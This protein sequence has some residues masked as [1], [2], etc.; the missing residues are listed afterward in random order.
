M[1]HILL[2]GAGKS[3]SYLIEYLKKISTDRKW[4]I[5]VAD[6]QIELVEEKVGKHEWVKSIQLSVFDNEKR[7]MLISQSKVVISLLPPDMHYLVAED[8]IEFRTHFLK[9]SYLDDK[10]T[11]Q[12]NNIE[13]ANILMIA[14][15]G[16]DPGIDHM[17]AM[18]IIDSIKAE[19]GEITSFKSHC[20]GLISLE[21]DDNPWH[22]KISWS[23]K[24]IVLAGKS[25][26]VYLEN[27]I[28]K[29]IPYTE[30]FNQDKTV[31]VSDKNVWGYY[32]NRNSLDYLP[33]YKLKKCETFIRTTLRDI[34]FLEGWKKIVELKLTDEEKLYETRELSY[35]DFFIMHCEKYEINES[36]FTDS[37]LHQ[38]HYLGLNS[39]ENI[40]HGLCSAADVLQ[41]AM[42][43]NL[44]LK[45]T[46]KDMIVM[47]HEIEY[48]KNN[49]K[50]KVESS[51]IVKGE[52]ATLTAMAKTVGLPLGI[53][54]KLILENKIQLRGLYLP[55]VKEIYLPV[56]DE[57]EKEGIVFEE[58]I[59]EL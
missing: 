42:E 4:N 50:Y 20:G 45:E 35:K 15:L 33:L 46:D 18:N 36:S 48:I 30:L 7:R 49:K 9:A 39:E 59:I 11:L 51:L 34:H 22:Y 17:S 41:T 56:L 6:Y 31:L 44:S 12:K 13:D 24:N 55:T 16:L 19:N 47:F 58:K 38:I 10:I 1:Y 32:P 23:P 40:N 27:N 52:D 57:L 37:F 26:A 54:A 25:G 53:A 14:E 3:A 21:S 28:Q 8:C 29:T 5:L 2:I 43:K